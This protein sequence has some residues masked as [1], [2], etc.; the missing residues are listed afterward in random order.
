MLRS[1]RPFPALLFLP[2]CFAAAPD[3]RLP[4]T[5][6]PERYRLEITL[7]PDQP[8]YSGHVEIDVRLAQSTTTIWLNSKDLA[9][10]SAFV[11]SAGRKQKAEVALEGG[12]FASLTFPSPAGP[13]TARLILDFSGHLNENA[14]QGLY[15]RS[16]GKHWYAYTAFT[17]I[18]ARRAFPC[19]DQP[20]F[21]TPW[22]LTLTVPSSNVAVANARALSETPVGDL[23]RVVFAE[24][25]PLPSEVVA[26]A[27]GPF[28][29]VPDG[30]AGRNAVKVRILTPAGHARD[31]AGARGATRDLLARFEDYT[32]VA[33]PWDKLDHLALLDSPFGAIENPGLITF[34]NAALLAG[35]RRNTP[36][37][38]RSLRSTMAHELAHQWFGNLVTQRWWD[39]V[40][41]SEGFATWLG[42][43]VSD[44]DV[45][46]W[47]KGLEAAESRARAMQMDNRAVRLDMQ[48]RD[49]M[50]DV[51]G[52]AVYVKA[53]A[54]IEM[55]EHW[56]GEAPFRRGLQRYLRAYA[57][58]NATTADL[59]SALAAETGLN[60]RGVLDSFLSRPGFPAIR[61]SADCGAMRLVLSPRSQGW[62]T[63][64][65]VQD[66]C[67]VVGDQDSSI[68][69]LACPAWANHAGTGYYRLET[70]KLSDLL[71]MGWMNLS[72]PERLALAGDIA[73]LPP[74]QQLA[75]LPFL[76]HDRDAR[77]LAAGQRI[78]LSLMAQPEYR[79]RVQEVVGQRR[80]R[81]G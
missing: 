36:E 10:P 47:E 34:Q 51:Y 6:R 54:I 52:G 32:G 38:R 27:A 81:S 12:E 28:D 8:D 18:E 46:E 68:P 33:Y 17:P 35:P 22:N 67:E 31:A 80:R 24:T 56:I 2:I 7:R 16:D 23:K 48:T 57:Y 21:K 45:P 41:L 61:A 13:G 37:H 40:W 1:A 76:L 55:V 49:A 39:D 50:R 60:V 14:R 42:I 53:G 20:E 62:K 79:E 63:P 44:R 19:F 75:A 70:E 26:F 15:R 25:R 71:Q 73:A 74:D 65:C 78:A 3:F 77:V 4:S 64:V 29:V 9:I 69:L 66:R 43:K 5:V 72:A 30:V 59:E 11:E 58:S